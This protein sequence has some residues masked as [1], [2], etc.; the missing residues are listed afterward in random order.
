MQYYLRINDEES[1]PY[2]I[3]DLKRLLADGHVT[4][5]SMV[6]RESTQFWKP[7]GE[8]LS[9]ADLATSVRPIPREPKPI[10]SGHK[11]KDVRTHLHFIRVYTNYP[12]L[13]RIIN[14][15]FWLTLIGLIVGLLG[16]LA[17]FKSATLHL[18]KSSF[19]FVFLSLSAAVISAMG[20]IAARLFLLMLVDLVDTMLHE[21]AR[22]K[23]RE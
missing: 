2:W 13:R 10:P 11:R 8:L 3:D 19:V 1:G 18:G 4:A 22:N 7:L 20:L 6:R 15:F 16:Q 17:A 5:D 14:V 12:T 21:H 23:Y 9:E